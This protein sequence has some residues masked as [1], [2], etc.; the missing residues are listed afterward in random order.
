MQISEDEVIVSD[1]ELQ[2]MSI[3]P[4]LD[5]LR[6]QKTISMLNLS[7]NMLG[8]HLDIVQFV[9][10]QF[11]RQCHFVLFP[12]AARISKEVVECNFLTK[13]RFTV[14]PKSATLQM[15]LPFDITLLF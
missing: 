11:F 4:L 12:H 7:H 1:C 6:T 15:F 9:P 3:V 8:K 2:D 13:Q 10:F 14:D 5:A